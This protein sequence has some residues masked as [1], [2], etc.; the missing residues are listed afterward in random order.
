MARR[1]YV[2]R[3]LR[4]CICGPFVSRGYVPGMID[5][6]RRRHSSAGTGSG[7]FDARNSASYCKNGVNPAVFGNGMS[8]R[9]CL[10]PK[11][12]RTNNFTGTPRVWRFPSSMIGNWPCSS[13]W[14]RGALCAGASWCFR[15][16]QRDMPLAVVLR[17]ATRGLRGAGRPGANSR[18]RPAAGFCRRRGDADGH[19]GTGDRSRRGGR[20]R[21][22]GG[23]GAAAPA[24]AGRIARGK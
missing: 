10:W 24:G 2:S 13:R 17:G 5:F 20:E 9:R 23:A 16:G 21:D 19:G 12:T 11:W 3:G 18:D 4:R 22:P 6:Q 1:N 15:A 8:K 14:A 7:S